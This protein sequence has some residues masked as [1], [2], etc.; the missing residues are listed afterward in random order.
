MGWGGDNKHHHLLQC[1][2][3]LDA[4]ES[5]RGERWDHLHH[6]VN[7]RNRVYITYTRLCVFTSRVQSPALFCFVYTE[8]RA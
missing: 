6:G 3:D 5:F 7:T 8:N 1:G 4:F 2:R